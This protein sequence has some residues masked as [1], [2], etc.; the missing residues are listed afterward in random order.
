M[1]DTAGKEEHL[2]DQLIN[3]VNLRGAYLLCQ[4]LAGLWG[5]QRPD[6]ASGVLRHMEEIDLGKVMAALWAVCWDCEGD[7]GA[8]GAS[9]LLPGGSNCLMHARG[10]ARQGEATPGKGETFPPSSI[11]C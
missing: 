8:G 2:I 9:G 11:R 7:D 10:L 3:S 1:I 5:T 6:S 4:V